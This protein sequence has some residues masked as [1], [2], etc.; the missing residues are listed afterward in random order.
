MGIFESKKEKMIKK[1]KRFHYT[2]KY[3]KKNV[4]RFTQQNKKYN[5]NFLLII[6]LIILFLSTYLIINYPI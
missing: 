4:I 3:D 5:S 1:N 6:M 2:P